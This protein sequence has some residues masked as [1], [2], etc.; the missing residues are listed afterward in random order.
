MYAKGMTLRDIQ[1]HLQSLYGI[2]I[3]PTMISQIT[4]KIMSVIKDWQQRP[5]QAIYAHLV[6]DAIHYK[7]RQDGKIVNKAVY[8]IIGIDLDGKKD[9]VGM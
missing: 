3:S 6:M 1:S 5:L 9:V 8:I 4:Q 2:E 7:V